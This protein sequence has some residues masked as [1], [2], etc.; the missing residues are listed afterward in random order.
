MIPETLTEI[1]RKLRKAVDR[2]QFGDVTPRLNELCR[3]ADECAAGLPEADPLRREL[4]A[5]MLETIEWIRL[6]LVTQ[7]QIWSGELARLPRIGRYLDQTESRS[8][9]VCVDL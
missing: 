8:P 9:D 3:M 6:M 7:R 4:A 5:W 1:G 2:R